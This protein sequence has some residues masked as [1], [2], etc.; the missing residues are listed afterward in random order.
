MVS[1]RAYDPNAA[2]LLRQATVVYSMADIRRNIVIARAENRPCNLALGA[3]VEV[4]ATGL[5]VP[6]ELV[7]FTL[8]GGGQYRLIVD[9][10][11]PT[12][13]NCRASPTVLANLAITLK[14]GV[15]VTRAFLVGAPTILTNV[16]VDATAGTLTN[17]FGQDAAGTVSKLIVET[18]SFLNVGH[19]FEAPNPT[20]T[21]KNSR[22]SDIT[23]TGV[24]AALVSLGQGATAPGF[25]FCRFERITGPLSIKPGPLSID[26]IFEA[27]EGDGSTATIDTTNSANPHVFINMRK[28]VTTT[29]TRADT[30]LGGRA[31]LTTALSRL[32]GLATAS[33]S[34]T[35]NSAG[36]TITPNASSFIRVTHL[37]GASGNVT[38]AAGVDGQRLVLYFVAVAGT[39]VYTTGAGNLDL[40]STWTPVAGALLELIYDATSSLWREVNRKLPAGAFIRTTVLTASGTHTTHANASTA[41]IRMTGGGGGG[42]GANTAAAPAVA[43]GG[44][45][46]GGGY[47]EA[48]MAVSPSTGYVFTR[49][50]GGLAGAA[51]AG[52]GGTGGSST[53]VVGATTYTAP[54]GAGGVG[55]AAAATAL[56]AAGGASAAIST[57]GSVNQGASDVGGAGI[58]LSSTVLM[59]GGG[60]GNPL[61]Q[62][63]AG[64]STQG[65]GANG[66]NGGNGGG[67]GAGACCIGPGVAVAGG[68]GA[69]GMIVI[70]E[71]T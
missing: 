59:S 18:A 5:T 6:A 31:N 13:V 43:V 35:L 51:A 53:F 16:D 11:L 33:S 67:G 21:W 50:A 4:G 54:G 10:G 7:S 39:A 56:I 36:P 19:I 62:G 40:A 68:A 15:T 61:A 44:G 29:L 45:G 1:P 65:V 52:T 23:T 20:G 24:G 63:T 64:R 49:G 48:T 12:L 30:V 71:Y 58:R 22:M 9:Q 28:F 25:D 46:G 34:S 66:S 14:A 17:V 55:M 8:D 37:A 57:N 60:G 32:T 27:C 42:G 3:S 38:I 2:R 26:T 70:D 69:P 41:F 47:L